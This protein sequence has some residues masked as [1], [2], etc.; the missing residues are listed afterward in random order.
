M[1]TEFDTCAFLEFCRSK[2]ADEEYDMTDSAVCALAQFGFPGVDEFVRPEAGI[3][4]EVYSATVWCDPYT[5]GALAD[6]LEKLARA[7]GIAQPW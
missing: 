6:R 5:F 3:P 4:P 1:T 7:E 2:P